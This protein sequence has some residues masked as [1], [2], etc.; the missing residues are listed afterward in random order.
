VLEDLHANS[1]NA[2]ARLGSDPRGFQANFHAEHLCDSGT[3]DQSLTTI[4]LSGNLNEAD[5]GL[6][7]PIR[8]FTLRL[9]YEHSRYSAGGQSNLY[10]NVFHIFAPEPPI[11]L[12]KR[13]DLGMASLAYHIAPAW[14]IEADMGVEG[15]P[16]NVSLTSPT[17]PASLSIPL[18]DHGASYL[19]TMRS[20][21]QARSMAMETL[22]LISPR[23][24]NRP[25]RG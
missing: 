11:G 10:K 13:E 7:W 20:P 8:N 14:N 3:L 17:S 6:V 16:G 2:N 25:M 15:S 4:G 22:P 24:D 18:S 23:W 1:S 19:Y 5:A 12:D 9:G 21:A